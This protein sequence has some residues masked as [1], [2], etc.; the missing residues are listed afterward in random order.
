[1]SAV[2]EIGDDTVAIREGVILLLLR[3]DRFEW[4]A[5]RAISRLKGMRCCLYH[6]PQALEG[7]S[8]VANHA[9]PRRF[10]DGGVPWVTFS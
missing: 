7:N 9:D 5:S 3:N 4:A 10:I 1:M 8:T 2:T 6:T